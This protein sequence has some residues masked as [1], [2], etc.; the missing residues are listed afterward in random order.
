[1]NIKNLLHDVY[2]LIRFPLCVMAAIAG[3]TAGMIVVL[4]QE[5]TPN[6][7]L[8]DFLK[9]YL[10]SHLNL[11]ILGL[12][13]PFLIVG[14]SMAINDYH[15]HE[16]DRINN[17]TDRPLVRNPNLDP[18]HVL[19]LSLLMIAIGILLSLI[20]FSNN[21]WVVFGVIFF[22]FLSILYNIWTK[23]MGLLGNIT[24]ATCDTAPYLLALIAMG[25][26]EVNTVLVVVIMSA[27]TFC[28]VTGRE[29]V[30]GIMDMEGD[31]AAGSNTFALRYSPRSAVILASLFFIGVIILAPVPLFI[32]FQNN[33]LYAFFIGVAIY[34]LFYTVIILLKDQSYESGK[35]ARHYT[36][37]A[38]WMGAIAF[39]VGAIC[40]P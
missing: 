29:L 10:Q 12:S 3:L 4:V 9:T 35:K 31:K 21:L 7:T 33:F 34:L 1:M 40:L 15:D 24:V 25:A 30:K 22:S 37:T 32:K 17:R 27:I 8:L 36:R 5:K 6:E 23:D 26:R 20:L 16:A 28:G 13:I 38:L 14:A 2:D 39:L 18:N 11:A 19:F